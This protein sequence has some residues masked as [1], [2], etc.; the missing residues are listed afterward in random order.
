V[1]NYVYFG[2]IKMS[3][4]VN[5]Y[6]QDEVLWEHFTLLVGR[7]NVSKWIENY[8]RPFVDKSD[9]ASSYKMMAQDKDRENEAQEWINGTFGDVGHESW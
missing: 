8:I 9:L 5:L 6:I 2:V 3:K 7:G 4:R 1:Y